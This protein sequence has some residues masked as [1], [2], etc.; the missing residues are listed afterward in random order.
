MDTAYV[1]TSAPVAVAFAQ[2]RGVEISQ[3][4]SGFDRLVSSN[5][6]EAE[7]RSAYA[8]EGRAFEPDVLDRIEWVYPT[9]PLTQEFAAVLSAGYLR[10]ADLWHV[11]VALYAF[12]GRIGETAFLTLDRRQR[13]VAAALGFQT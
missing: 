6:L 7:T 10:G 2:Q 4:L 11:A 8:R 13:A 1:D 12:P 9:R 5:L 3:R